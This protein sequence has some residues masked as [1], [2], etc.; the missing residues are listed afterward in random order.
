MLRDYVNSAWD[1]IVSDPFDGCSAEIDR[2]CRSG[3][4]LGIGVFLF[5][6]LGLLFSSSLFSRDVDEG[7]RADMPTCCDWNISAM[8]RSSSASGDV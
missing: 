6:V 2:L 8:R 7:S 4:G 1:A 3:S 5:L